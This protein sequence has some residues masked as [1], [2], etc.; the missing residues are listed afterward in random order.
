MHKMADGRK[1]VERIDPVID[2]SALFNDVLQDNRILEPLRQMFGEDPV[3][4][5]DKLIFKVPG[6]RGYEM[7]QDYAWWQ[8]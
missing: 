1:V 5:K 7:H 6:M 2:V 4:F 8:P 3:L